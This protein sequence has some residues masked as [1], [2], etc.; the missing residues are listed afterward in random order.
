MPVQAPGIPLAQ[1]HEPL[2][3]ADGAARP[4]EDIAPGGLDPAAEA[5]ATA[6]D[7]FGEILSKM[8]A[9]ANTTG[10]QAS[11]AAQEF[12]AGTR[13]D[14]HGTM[15]AMSKADIEFRLTSNVRNKIVDAFYEL[16]RM[17]V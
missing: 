15:I 2:P 1:P 8:V 13:D 3:I 7:P 16:W 17:Q 10:M 11:Q 14:I 12:A 5:P 6:V 4:L 9:S